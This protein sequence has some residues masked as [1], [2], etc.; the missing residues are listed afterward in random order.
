MLWSLLDLPDN[1]MRCGNDS[2]AAQ[3]DVFPA[4]PSVMESPRKIKAING[5][6]CFEACFSGGFTAAAAMVTQ[7]HNCGP[8]LGL[9]MWRSASRGP[10]WDGGDAGCYRVLC[11]LG[12][13]CEEQ[14]VSVNGAD[15]EHIGDVLVGFREGRVRVDGG[16][17]VFGGGA[18]FDGQR[19]GAAGGRFTATYI[20]NIPIRSY[21]A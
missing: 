16:G 19:R 6:P 1:W 4:W 2:G 11:D 15:A 12:V 8:A 3:F 9:V 5:L 13:L 18:H 10:I 20:G 14:S 17:G 7:P 21:I